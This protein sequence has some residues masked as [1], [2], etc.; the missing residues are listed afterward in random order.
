MLEAAHVSVAED[1]HVCMRRGVGAKLLHTLHA[2]GHAVWVGCLAAIDKRPL[3]ASAELSI[4]AHVANSTHDG[5]QALSLSGL[6][7][8]GKRRVDAFC[9][10][11]VVLQLARCQKSSQMPDKLLASRIA[12]GSFDRTVH[13]QIHDLEEGGHPDRELRNVNAPFSKDILDGLDGVRA[14]AV[15]NKEQ[16]PQLLLGRAEQ[17]HPHTNRCRPSRSRL[18]LA[19]SQRPR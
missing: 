19:P 8:W 2:A 3:H 10:G 15:P 16:L 13:N 11:L 18:C 1:L 6:G 12:N 4:H 17:S 9:H 7:G 14:T 5:H